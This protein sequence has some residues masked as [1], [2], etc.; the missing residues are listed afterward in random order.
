M[1]PVAKHLPSVIQ[2]LDTLISTGNLSNDTKAEAHGLKTYFQSFNAVLLLT[3]WTKVLQ[4]IEDR[5]IISQSS[6]ISLDVQAANIKELEVEIALL[7]P[8][9]NNFLKEATAVA[10]DMGISAKIEV[11]TRKR[12]RFF[13]EQQT[14]TEVQSPEDLFRDKVF[15]AAMDSIMSHLETRFQSMQQICSEFCVLWKFREMPEDSIK[16]ACKN[17]TEKYK[18]DLTE[19][20]Q[21]QILHIKKIYSA[22][23]K[24]NLGS[25][26][27]LN[28][29]YEMGLQSIYG[30]L[31]ILLRIFLS[32]PVTVA[33]GERAFSKLKLIKNYLCSKMS[34]ERLNGLAMLS[35]EHKLAK[36][37]D[38]NDLI[39]DF[40]TTKVRRMAFRT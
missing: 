11:K 5:N 30:D 26:D 36:K 7:R 31:C 9:W 2:A 16:E 23:F 15:N 13:D 12:K 1:R 27:L 34:Q 19:S 20:I 17:L 21:D 18:S 25:L 29:I 4:C 8:S 28:A 10:T 14:E 24:E 35:I 32:M 22:T 39:D 3:F 38:F 33:G 6:T 40:A 37:L